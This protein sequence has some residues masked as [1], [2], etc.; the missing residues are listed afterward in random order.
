[1]S[2]AETIGVY[3][4]KA[5]SY[6]KLVTRN[7]PDADLQAF[8]DLMPSGGRVL[9]FGCGPGNSAAMMRAHGL[10]V[11]ATDASSEMVKLAR[12]TYGVEARCETF[13]MLDAQERYDGIWANF[14][15]L[16]APKSDFAWHLNRVSVALKPEGILHLGM[17]TGSGEMRDSIGRMYSYFTAGE[18][19][20]EMNAQ[21]FS[22]SRERHGEAE[23]LAGDVEPFIILLASKN[24]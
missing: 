8:L 2:D 4:A 13:D 11:E 9:D 3:D 1:M 12:D 5:S 16:H 19:H 20:G 7:K 24:A 22:V 15:L 23:G 6:A 14:S 21:G 17:K 18:L 10:E